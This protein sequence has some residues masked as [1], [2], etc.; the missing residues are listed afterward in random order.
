VNGGQWVLLAVTNA[1]SALIGA[2]AVW[3]MME[4]RVDR[5]DAEVFGPK[6]ENGMRGEV[7]ALRLEVF[8]GP[9]AESLTVRARHGARNAMMAPVAEV[10]GR[11]A[12]MEARVRDL[13]RQQDRRT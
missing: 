1:L 3:R 4:K 6:G 5:L 10:E 2:A 12:G 11:I 8:G 13:E 9:G 7:K